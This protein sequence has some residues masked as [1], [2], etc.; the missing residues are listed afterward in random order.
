LP[1][2][3]A[4]QFLFILEVILEFVPENDWIVVAIVLRVFIEGLGKIF[5]NGVPQFA[6]ENFG[7][8]P[9]GWALSVGRSGVVPACPFCLF[10]VI[11]VLPPI[12]CIPMVPRISMQVE[13][14]SSR[15]CQI[16]HIRFVD[17]VGTCS[18]MTATLTPNELASRTRAA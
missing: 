5:G 11:H 13:A 15:A 10:S 8:D 1:E 7:R 12:N 16:G 2:Q 9:G 6:L 17:G 18:T 4:P 14:R 3:A